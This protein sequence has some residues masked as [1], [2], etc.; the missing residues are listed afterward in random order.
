MCKCNIER[1][2]FNHS[3]HR[4]AINLTYAECVSVDLITEYAKRMRGIILLSVD[5]LP[6]PHIISKRHGFWRQVFEHKMCILIF[7]T[8]LA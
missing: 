3:C 4:K 7:S 2:L 5:H 6:L 1:R 8:S